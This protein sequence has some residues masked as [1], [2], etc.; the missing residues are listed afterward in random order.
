[1]MPPFLT[2]SAASITIQSMGKIALCARCE[3]VVFIFFQQDLPPSGKLP[4]LNLLTG[5]KSAFLPRRATCCTDSC[6]IWRD[7]GARGSAWPSE[8][9]R[10]SVNGGGKAAPK[11]ENFHFSVKS[12]PAVANPLDRFLQLLGVFIL[13]TILQ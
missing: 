10:Q 8:I 1:M 6:E 12:R 2:A 3:N 7:Q 13:P 4:V 9:S 11:V 5:R